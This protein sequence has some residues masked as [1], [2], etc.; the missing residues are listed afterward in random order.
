MQHDARMGLFSRK[1]RAPQWQPPTRPACSCSRHLD[2]ELLASVVPYAPSLVDDIGHLPDP[3]T[4]RDLLNPGGL[5]V[6]PTDPDLRRT[7]EDE[8]YVWTLWVY[9]DARAHYDDDAH[10][11]LDA[12]LAAQPGVD[13]ADWPDREELLLAA[14]TLCADGVL[15]AGALAL[16]DDRVR[17][18]A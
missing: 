10:L 14:P 11:D 17:T 8:H 3:V 1:A 9:D 5:S 6:S 7:P 18:P 12:A 4:V 2:D 16:L 15:A 13:D